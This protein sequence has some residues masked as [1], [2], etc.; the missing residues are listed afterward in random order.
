MHFR[1]QMFCLATKLTTRLELF[2]HFTNKLTEISEVIQHKA[3][4]SVIMQLVTFILHTSLLSVSFAI[5]SVSKFSLIR[6][7]SLTFSWSWSFSSWNSWIIKDIRQKILI[8]WQWWHNQTLPVVIFTVYVQFSNIFTEN[9]MQCHCYMKCESILF[10]IFRR[11]Q[12][13][14]PCREIFESIV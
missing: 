13:S 1:Q 11:L 6:L 5:F 12:N 7:F 8:Q 14:T 3:S 10:T 2:E 9:F 4:K